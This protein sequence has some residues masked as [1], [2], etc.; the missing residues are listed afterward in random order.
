MK[1]LASALAAFFT[2]LKGVPGHLKEGFR[3]ARIGLR[4]PDR[5]TRRMAVVFYL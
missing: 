2:A 5:P 4:S 3:E 1:G